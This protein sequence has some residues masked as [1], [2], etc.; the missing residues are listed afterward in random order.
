MSLFGVDALPPGPLDLEG[1][2]VGQGQVTRMGGTV[3]VSVLVDDSWRVAA[4]FDEFRS[5]GLA[6]SWEQGAGDG[7]FWVRTAYAAALAD[8]ARRWVRCA[9]KVVPRGFT[10]DGHRLRLWAA[11]AGVMEGSKAYTL[12]LGAADG[13]AVWQATGKALAAAG[14]PSVLLGPL[15]GG[16]AYRVVGRRR[17][18]RLVELVG[19]PP[20]QAPPG[21]WPR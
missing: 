14:L 15:A 4:L 17:L 12:S 19:E 16:P 20:A 7:R 21:T 18:A 11:A 2:L 10:L 13:A 9:V 3:R 5:R 1:L 8:L 6:S